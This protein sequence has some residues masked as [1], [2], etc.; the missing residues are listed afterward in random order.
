MHLI[1][2]RRSIAEEHPWLPMALLKAFEQSKRMALAHL[3]ETS[4]TKVTLPF[5]EEQIH[6]A[7]SIMGPDFWSYGLPANRHVLEA[8]VRHHHAQGISSRLVDV[9]ELFHPGTTEEFKI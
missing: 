1:G 2:V 5:I 3:G 4:A 9:D 6:R 7:R 8:F